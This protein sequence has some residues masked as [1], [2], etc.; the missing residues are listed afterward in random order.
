[1]EFLNDILNIIWKASKSWGFRYVC[2]IVSVAYVRYDISPLCLC[3]C[4]KLKHSTES[5]L[6]LKTTLGVKKVVAV[7]QYYI[8]RS[9][10]VIRPLIFALP[11]KELS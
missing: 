4:V 1:M 2:N 10:S 9:P 11:R 6:N 5:W 8:D 7:L 3:L